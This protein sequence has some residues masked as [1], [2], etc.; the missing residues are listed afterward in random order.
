MSDQPESSTLAGSP[1][2]STPPGFFVPGRTRF[3]QPNQSTPLGFEF[4][5]DPTEALLICSGDDEAS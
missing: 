2:P 4:S 3:P 5:V 1:M